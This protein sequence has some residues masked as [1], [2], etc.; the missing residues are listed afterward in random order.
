M[1][2]KTIP[3]SWRA[4]RRITQAA[5]AALAAQFGPRVAELV[6]AVTNPAYAPDRD[7]V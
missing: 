6:G 5:L 1:P 7:A 4:A 3:L 2:W